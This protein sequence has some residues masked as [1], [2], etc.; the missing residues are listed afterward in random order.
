MPDNEMRTFWDLLQFHDAG[1]Y[2]RI[3]EYNKFFSQTSANLE[4][5]N[6]S[7]KFNDDPTCSSTQKKDLKIILREEQ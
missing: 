6:I 2:A 4:E 1:R 3:C 7:R 5:V